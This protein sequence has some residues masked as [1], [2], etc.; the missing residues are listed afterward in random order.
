MTKYTFA[1]F[2]I[3][4]LITTPPSLANDTSLDDVKDENSCMAF[5]TPLYN[6]NLSL[7]LSDAQERSEVDCHCFGEMVEVIR[8][9]SGISNAPIYPI[10][11]NLSVAR[12]YQN[13]YPLEG[14][15]QIHKNI[16]A[17]RSLFET[18]EEAAKVAKILL[19]H[20]KNKALN[21]CKSNLLS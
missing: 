2:L 21:V 14:R 19:N 18:E 8:Q 10:I 1:L 17:F 6:E 13:A 9:E 11:W 15:K 7:K 20:Q 16:A 3:I 4:F 5:L 12:I